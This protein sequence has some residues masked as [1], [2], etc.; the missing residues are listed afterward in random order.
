MS[1]ANRRRR[2]RA[3]RAG[4]VGTAFGAPLV[5]VTGTG[6]RIGRETYRATSIHGGLVTLDRQ[7]RER[8]EWGTPVYEDRR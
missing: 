4:V 6:V 8:V 2:Y 1:R 5:F 7:L 3:R